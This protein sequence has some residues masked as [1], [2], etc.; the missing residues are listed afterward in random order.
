MNIMN[1]YLITCCELKLIISLFIQS[2]LETA[3][4]RNT[5]NRNQIRCGYDLRTLNISK[6]HCPYVEIRSPRRGRH[7]VQNTYLYNKI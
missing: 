5:P 2:I 7:F 4:K 6:R 3:M 1:Y